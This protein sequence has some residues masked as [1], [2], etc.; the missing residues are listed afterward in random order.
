MAKILAISSQVVHGHVGNSAGAFILQ[1][2]G[3]EVLN[4]PTVILSNRPGYKAIAGERASAEK[5]HSLMRAIS[6]NGW[7]DTIDAILTGYLPSA[8]IVEF[9]REW[10]VKIKSARPQATYLCDPI[11]GD[12]PTGLYIDGAAAALIRD[13]LV[14]LADIVTPNA[15]ELSWL[16]RRPAA[17]MQAAVEAARSLSRPAVVVTSAPAA[18]PGMLANILVRGHEVAATASE[19]RRVKAMAWE[20]FSRAFFSRECWQA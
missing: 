14:P 20:T 18:Q 9:C 7:L 2:L 1:R 13:A 11:I 5:L 16:A 17:D 15:F 10:V 3:H 8:E 6:D 19:R 12:E 4:L